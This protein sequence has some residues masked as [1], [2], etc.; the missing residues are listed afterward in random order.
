MATDRETAPA[1]TNEAPAATAVADL[2][3]H[4]ARVA[5]S[6]AS[7][8]SYGA[9]LATDWPRITTGAPATAARHSPPPFHVE[10]IVVYPEPVTSESENDDDDV[11]AAPPTTIVPETASVV[12]D[13]AQPANL[14]VDG[15]HSGSSGMDEDD[16]E[17]EDDDASDKSVAMS[18][19]DGYSD[20]ELVDDRC[21]NCDEGRALLE[22]GMPLCRECANLE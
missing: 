5:T 2:V 7:V 10:C 13:P 19:L 14:A 1:V 8:A 17:S 9:S 16:D 21:E 20:I 12:E 4:G 15:D 3:M 22:W 6:D 18:W 11:R